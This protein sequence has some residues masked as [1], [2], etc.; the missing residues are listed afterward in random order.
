M[1]TKMNQRFA[2][3]VCHHS[4]SNCNRFCCEWNGFS[5]SRVYL[6]TLAFFQVRMLNGGVGLSF[7]WHDGDRIFLWKDEFLKN[8]YLLLWC[9]YVCVWTWISKANSAESVLSSQIRLVSRNQAQV[10]RLARKPLCLLSHLTGTKFLPLCTGQ[11]LGSAVTVS[12]IASGATVSHAKLFTCS[13]SEASVPLHKQVFA[14]R[15][16]HFLR[17]IPWAVPVRKIP[18]S[19]SN[20]M[21]SMGMV[22]FLA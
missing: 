5:I 7:S 11:R 12:K 13:T 22:Y 15:W 4:Q 3:S 8:T 16:N 2:N 17:L 19:N 10:T 14:D 18:T 1:E 6:R 20:P 21:W 9:V